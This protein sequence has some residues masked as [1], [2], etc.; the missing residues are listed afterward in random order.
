[1]K[2]PILPGYYADPFVYQDGND[3]YMVFTTETVQDS[4]DGA[5]IFEIS[6]STNLAEWSDP[7]TILTT[8]QLSWAEKQPWAPTLTKYQDHWYFFFCAERQIGVAVSDSPMGPYRDVLDC[9]LIPGPYFMDTQTIDPSV[10]VD[11]DGRAYLL[12]GQ[13]NALLCE[14]HLSPTDVHLI[15]KPIVLSDHFLI[16]RSHPL[17]QR[18]IEF[19]NEGV[20]LM[21]F[22]GRYL[23]TWSVYDTRDYRYN[24]RY[25]WADQVTG[26]Y[27]QPLTEGQD[28]LMIR[29][30]PGIDATGHGNPV[31]YQGELY[32]FYH[33]YVMP[34]AGYHREICCDK[35]KIDG[36]IL[37]VIPTK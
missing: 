22:Q 29:R 8:K 20:D 32:Q 18:H 13:K 17:D 11:D 23:L 37:T 35:I 2:N 24:I 31:E 4:W 34:R 21:K 16:Q 5:G 30:T 10:F 1:M 25:A 15:G 7:L 9:P 27:I 28:N 3:Y 33:R 14:I 6:H 36:D 12:W 26:P 19:Y